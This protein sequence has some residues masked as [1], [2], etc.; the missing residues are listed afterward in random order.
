MPPEQQ[1]LKLARAEIEAVLLKYD[2]AGFATLHG[3]GGWGEVF[4]NI[5]PSYSV[6]IGDFPAIRIRSKAADY[7][8]NPG[9]QITDQAQTAQMAHHLGMSMGECAVQFIELATVLNKAVGAEHEDLGFVHDPSKDDPMM[10]MKAALTMAADTFEH[11]A[12]LHA[13]KGTPDGDAKAQA[14]R[15]R[16][17]LCREALTH[18]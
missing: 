11:Y 15:D 2:I 13:A 5:W 7:A 1:K 12:T 17:L 8:A 6:L 3:G 9:K 4:W 18:A 10:A 16:A 14:N